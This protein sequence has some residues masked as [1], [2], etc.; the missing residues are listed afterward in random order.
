MGIVFICK[1]KKLIGI[2][3]EGDIRRVLIKRNNLDITLG[4]FCKKRFIYSYRDFDLSKL[5][6][7][8]FKLNLKA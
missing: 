3:T 1:N 4:K 2:I 7:I 8:F 6:Q 5:K